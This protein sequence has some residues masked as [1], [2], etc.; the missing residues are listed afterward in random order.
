MKDYRV[1]T[2][3]PQV[4]G[5]F[6]LSAANPQG[7]PAQLQI[8]PTHDALDR[9]PAVRATIYLGVDQ[10]AQAGYSLAA[11]EQVQFTIQWGYGGA[12]FQETIEAGAGSF[13]KVGD[14]FRVSATLV[15]KAGSAINAASK[16]TVRAM[17]VPVAANDRRKVTKFWTVNGAQGGIPVIAGTVTGANTITLLRLWG[18]NYGVQPG[19]LMLFDTSTVITPANGTA[20]TY[21]VGYVPVQGTFSLDVETTGLPFSQGCTYVMSST[22]DTLTTQPGAT[23]NVSAEFLPQPGF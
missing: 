20:P 2:N 12:I 6:A 4:G 18:Y 23:I 14:N 10:S 8:E 13:Q 15:P 3:R 1:S 21:V 11:G 5:Q 17:I 19:Y 22:G 9:M 7:T 16:V